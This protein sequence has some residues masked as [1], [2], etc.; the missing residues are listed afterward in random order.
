MDKGSMQIKQ[1]ETHKNWRTEIKHMGQCI[2]KQP[3]LRKLPLMQTKALCNI[4]EPLPES[5]LEE[6]YTTN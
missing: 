6:L 5:A 4:T 1:Y 3:A 2:D